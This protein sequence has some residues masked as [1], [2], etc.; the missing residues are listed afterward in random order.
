MHSGQNSV[1]N[2]ELQSYIDKIDN[3]AQTVETFPLHSNEKQQIYDK[4]VK[5]SITFSFV[6]QNTHHEHILQQRPR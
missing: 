3:M 2:D 4:I 6:E 5:V 1:T